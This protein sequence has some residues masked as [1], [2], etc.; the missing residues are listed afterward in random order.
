MSN[1]TC[2]L[3]A[4]SVPSPG[5]RVHKQPCELLTVSPIVTGEEMGTWS[6]ARGNQHASCFLHCCIPSASRVLST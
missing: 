1:S 6:L 3:G 4:C 2:S 5:L